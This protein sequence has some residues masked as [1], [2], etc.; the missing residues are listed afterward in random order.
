MLEMARG[1]FRTFE[2]SVDNGGRPG[3]SRRSR[4]LAG[5][6]GGVPEWSAACSR[7]GAD[8]WDVRRCSMGPRSPQEDLPGI[9]TVGIDLIP[10]FSK[11]VREIRR[12]WFG[13]G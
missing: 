13:S 1:G 2:V 10:Q 6:R 7:C 11:L 9:L 12:P 5:A 8:R 3:P 4:H